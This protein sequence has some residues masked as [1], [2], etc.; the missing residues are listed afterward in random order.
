MIGD[1][2]VKWLTNELIILVILSG[3]FATIVFRKKNPRISKALFLVRVSFCQLGVENLLWE[4]GKGFIFVN[5]E[6]MEAQETW[7]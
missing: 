2:P 6:K 1:L 7:F 5:L 4:S 3:A